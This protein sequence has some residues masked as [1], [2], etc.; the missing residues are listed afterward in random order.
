[1]VKTA[2][3][4]NAQLA[5][6]NILRMGDGINIVS[7]NYALIEGKFNIFPYEQEMNQDIDFNAKDALN[8]TLDSIENKVASRVQNELGHLL[9]DDSWDMQDREQWEE[10]LAKITSKEFLNADMAVSEYRTEGRRTSLLNETLNSDLNSKGKPTGEFDCEAMSKLEGV[11]IQRVENQALKGQQHEPGNLKFPGNYFVG[12]GVVS[13]A[14]AEGGHAHLLS[15]VTGNIIEATGGSSGV[16]GRS[17]Q[18]L[19]GFVAGKP[20]IVTLDDGTSGVYGAEHASG[21]ADLKRIVSRAKAIEN[22]QLDRLDDPSMEFKLDEN[23]NNR[24]RAERVAADKT[25]NANSRGYSSQIETIQEALIELDSD[26][27]AK[28][29]EPKTGNPK[30]AVDGLNGTNTKAGIEEFARTNGLDLTTASLK[31]IEASIG[32]KITNNNPENTVGEPNMADNEQ[33]TETP[34]EVKNQGAGVLNQNQPISTPPPPPIPNSDNRGLTI[35]VIQGLLET[36]GAKQLIAEDP[37]FEG[38]GDTEKLAELPDDEYNTEIAQYVALNEATTNSANPTRGADPVAA[39][40]PENITDLLAILEKPEVASLVS[41]MGFDM[42]MFEKIFESM[43][44]MLGNLETPAAPAQKQ[45]AAQPPTQTPNPDEFAD[46]PAVT[47][48]EAES[49]ANEPA[50]STLENPAHTNL[51][52]EQ[53]AAKLLNTDVVIKE[54][55][56]IKGSGKSIEK[57]DQGVQ[58]MQQALLDL[59]PEKYGDILKYK[60]SDGADGKEGSRTRDAIKAFAEEQGLD[61]KTISVAQI[62]IEAKTQEAGKGYIVEDPEATPKPEETTSTFDAS[63]PESYYT[64]YKADTPD[65]NAWGTGAPENQVE[66][67]PADVT[68]EKSAEQPKLDWDKGVKFFDAAKNIATGTLTNM[69]DHSAHKKALE[70]GKDGLE[71]G[72]NNALGIN[73]D[74]AEPAV[75]DDPLSKDPDQAVTPTVPGGP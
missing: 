71:K 16:Y 64:P 20:C 14:G 28:L 55:S 63:R 24:M 34:E 45:P 9:R 29:L 69:W 1:M 44:A 32:Q 68:E 8:G 17:N 33:A 38:L 11:I 43:K 72:I 57:Y 60:G 26:K 7:V 2:N 74:E 61:P 62:I 31:E 46:E 21:K 59:D 37:R 30:D 70:F 75:N 25:Y 23:S 48:L 58:L 53:G 6:S 13:F 19:A 47:T 52:N 4:Y 67:N 5:S 35:N 18:T 12:G 15:S 42:G 39:D 54:R 51:T 41:S 10:G 36:E 40:Q 73:N 56:A 65:A 49:F 27:Y 22:G 50:V 66:I 3:D